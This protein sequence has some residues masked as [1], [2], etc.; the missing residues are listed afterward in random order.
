MLTMLLLYTD[1]LFLFA[2][3]FLQLFVL[4][5]WKEHV[6]SQSRILLPSGT[7]NPFTRESV[8]AFSAVTLVSENCSHIV[9]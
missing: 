1:V 3:N 2:C 5:V 7:D 4:S 6:E 8:R 9:V